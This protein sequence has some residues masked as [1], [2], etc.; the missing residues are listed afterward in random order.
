K[1]RLIRHGYSNPGTSDDR[2]TTMFPRV[3][4]TSGHANAGYQPNNP[5]EMRSANRGRF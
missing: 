2:Q 4:T 1:K 5:Y 3:Q